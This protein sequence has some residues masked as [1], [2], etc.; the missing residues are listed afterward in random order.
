MP[1]FDFVDLGDLGDAASVDSDARATAL[2]RLKKAIARGVLTS[3]A[4]L[5]V[6]SWFLCAVED[7]ADAFTPESLRSA[8]CGLLRTV[9]DSDFLE[10]LSCNYDRL[11]ARLSEVV[12]R[13][14]T[15]SGST[16]GAAAALGVLSA[17]CTK[18]PRLQAVLGETSVAEDAATLM[19]RMCDPCGVRASAAAFLFHAVRRNP[20][21][22]KKACSVR[23]ARNLVDFASNASGI[24]K[25]CAILAV[26]EFAIADAECRAMFMKLDIIRVLCL[27][28]DDTFSP[29]QA[30]ALRTVGILASSQPALQDFAREE[31]SGE[32]LRAAI[33]CVDE[34]VTPSVQRQATYALT[35]LARRCRKNQVFIV[36]NGGVEGLTA[37]L[38]RCDFADSVL[39]AFFAVVRENRAVKKHML[40]ASPVVIVSAVEFLRASDVL[41]QRQAAR[42]LGTMVDGESDVVPLVVAHGAVVPLLALTQSKDALSQE[43]A[44]AAV[45]ALTFHQLSRPLVAACL[46]RENLCAVLLDNCKPT[47]AARASA[48]QALSSLCLTDEGMAPSLRAFAIV[49]PLLRYSHRS[50]TFRLLR[51][52]A[53]KLLAQIAPELAGTVLAAQTS[54]SVLETVAPFKNP[55]HECPVCIECTDEDLLYLPCFHAFHRTCIAAWFEVGRDTCPVCKTATLVALDTPLL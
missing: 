31:N 23:V 1:L 39:A 19:R 50:C 44:C 6:S 13:A 16:A 32:L 9:A 37:L 20:G 10:R 46:G 15:G 25:E 49:P 48:V 36:D 35:M 7:L 55:T 12:H 41:V 8:A 40:L 11:A 45:A 47:N 29:V 53:K 2:S 33:L 42:F 30:A 28:V 14:T 21:V 52:G 27:A 17:L 51:D 22:A 34:S 4:N 24:P 26:G 3:R 18:F 5:L 43:Y 54:L 38:A